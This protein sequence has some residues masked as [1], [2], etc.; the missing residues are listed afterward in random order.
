[1]IIPSSSQNNKTFNKTL[2]PEFL[3]TE[4]ASTLDSIKN[5]TNFIDYV[6]TYV[7]ELSTAINY[8]ATIQA[9]DQVSA[10]SDFYS[11]LDNTYLDK[12][13]NEFVVYWVKKYNNTVKTIKD[14]TKSKLENENKLQS[15]YDDVS[16]SIGSLVNSKVKLD[17]AVIPY[18]DTHLFQ[19]S[20]PVTWP[21]SINNKLSDNAKEISEELSRR[22]TT[23]LRTN[24]VNIQYCKRGVM[25]D[26]LDPTVAHSVNLITDLNYF[27]ENVKNMSSFVKLLQKEFYRTFNYISYYSNLN[28]SVAY[29]PRNF[30]ENEIYSNLQKIYRYLIDVKVEGLSQKLDLLNKK[31]QP[32]ITPTTI[33]RSLASLKSTLSYNAS[34]SETTSSAIDT[35]YF[36]TAEDFNRN[37]FYTTTENLNINSFTNFTPRVNEFIGELNQRFTNPITKLDNQLTQI[38]SQNTAFQYVSEISSLGVPLG[39]PSV[40]FSTFLPGNFIPNLDNTGI[41]GSISQITNLLGNFGIPNI[42]PKVN[43]GSLQTLAELGPSIVMNPAMIANPAGALQLVQSLKDVVCN[44][45]PPTV[46]TSGLYDFTLSNPFADFE[47]KIQALINNFI[48]FFDFSKLAEKIKFNFNNVFKNF[49]DKFFKC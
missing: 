2:Y 4:L 29:N 23:L 16:D 19:Y 36:N 1:M 32:V 26:K 42:I 6:G 9:S 47:S 22:T 33:Q 7:T 28:D 37:R 38:L 18:F 30:S 17:D 13:N 41:T 40:D 43:F 35:Q 12:F 25:I 39:L 31:A 45:V 3:D 21:V 11:S 49:F 24:L 46:D 27:N 15:Y 20:Q 8:R 34:A 14:L 5:Y 44:F 10:L 48:N